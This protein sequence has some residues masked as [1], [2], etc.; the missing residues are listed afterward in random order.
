M[1]VEQSQTQPQQTGQAR[2]ARSARA[3]AADAQT[4]IARL[5]RAVCAIAPARAG[6]ALRLGEDGAADALATHPPMDGNGERPAWLAAAAFAAHAAARQRG[7][8][9]VA[10]QDAPAQV[11][12]ALRAGDALLAAPVASDQEARPVVFA[13]FLV[14]EASA[15]ER[16][17][18]RGRIEL[19]SSLLG[20]FELRAALERERAETERLRRAMSLFAEVSERS[21]LFPAAAA[22][23]NEAASRWRC[24][25]VSLGFLRGRFVRLVAMSG[26]EKLVR[27]MRLA[28]DI[29]SAMEECVDQDVEVAHPADPEQPIVS[30][31]ARELSNRHGPMRIVSLPIRDGDEA[32]GALTLERDMDCPWEQDEVD[33]LRL[34]LDLLSPRLLELRARDR[35]FGA[36]AG[37]AA[38]RG[39]AKLI[40]PERTWLKLAAAAAFAGALF[41]A[42]AKGR[43]RVGADFTIEPA[44]L[45][46]APAPFAGF[47]ES[48]NVEVGDPVVANET[49]LATL[50]TSQLRLQLAA[51]RAQLA[52]RETQAA[53]H[54]R[55][56]EVAQAQMAQAQADE[57]RAQISL[58]EAQIAQASI[59][60]PIS[61]VVISGDLKRMLGAPVNVGDALFQVAPLDSMEATLRV[62]EDQ[63]ADVRIGADCALAPAADPASRAPC[64]VARIDPIA[65]VVEGA[66][67]FRVR[68]RLT[69]PADWLRP[70]MEGSARIDAGRRNYL[71]IWLRP[72]A[73]W[74]RMQLWL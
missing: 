65:E 46:V 11:S 45:Q 53:T 8:V 68:A 28:Q 58:L 10:A 7:A 67:V 13:V 50:D 3:A 39:L 23:V 30:R 6:A 38:R 35:W 55:D 26:A 29:E 43:Y 41:L 70:G 54:R 44:V 64:S 25:R 48:V 60:S 1:A 18:Q 73:N 15:A 5:L 71:W 12:R 19:A 47:L 4:P 9:E 22:I 34:A 74:A 59:T 40:G 42:L 27:K 72:I 51:L 31:E 69:E 32:V 17:L 62:P 21:R 49:V 14:G 36:R 37:S 20:V 57:A 66:N 61:G 56:G 16:V 24:E 33:A 52:A 63:I 2:A